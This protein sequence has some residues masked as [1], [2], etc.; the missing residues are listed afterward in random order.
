M[1]FFFSVK[2]SPP[3]LRVLASP[4]PPSPGNLLDTALPYF[5]GEIELINGLVH[6]E[7]SLPPRHSH[8]TYR[9]DQT[10]GLLAEHIRPWF[11]LALKVAFSFAFLTQCHFMPFSL[12]PENTTRQELVWTLKK[13]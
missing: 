2:I 10:G 11:N 12:H 13:N 4:L 3:E 5:G 1:P 9:G 6:T 8:P 7:L